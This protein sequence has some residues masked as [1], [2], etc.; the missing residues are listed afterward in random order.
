MDKKS[1]TH[2]KAWQ[3]PELIVLVRS[4]PEETVLVTCKNANSSVLGPNDPARKCKVKGLSC[5]L[6]N[7]S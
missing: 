7:K 4:N 1:L 5:F 6:V 2:K 3:K